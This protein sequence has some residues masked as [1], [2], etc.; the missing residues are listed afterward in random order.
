MPDIV[1]TAVA[2]VAW[3]ITIKLKQAIEFP[4]DPTI[5]ELTFRRGRMGDL[6]GMPLEGTPSIDQLLLMASRMCGHPVKALELLGEEDI[7]EVLA[8]PL[9]FFARCLRGGGTA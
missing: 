6:R 9:G 8:V 2:Q 7:T 3:P 5:T 1:D 4:G